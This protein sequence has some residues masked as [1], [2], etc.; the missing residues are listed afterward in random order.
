MAKLKLPDQL[1]S[2]KVLSG[3]ASRN[4]HPAFSI[5]RT[6]FDG[7]RTDAV[8]TV[9]S[10]AGD[11]YTSENIDFINEE[12]AF[13][14]SV[15]NLRGVSNYIDAVVD[16][17]PSKERVTLFLVTYD[18]PNLVEALAGKTFDDNE[19][20]DFG[21]QMS[22]LLDK[23]ERSNIFHGNIRPENIYL[24]KNGR[25]QLGGFTAF[26][27]NVEDMTYSA[28]ELSEGK[29]P[30]YTTDIY[31]LGL[32]MYEMSNGGKL[33]FEEETGNRKAATQER[34]SKAS[35][36]A[37][38]NGSEKLK[39]VV[40]IACQPDNKNRWKN[41]GN[42]KNA[43]TSIKADIPKAQER[44]V[45]APEST[46]FESNVFEENAFDEFEE[47][48]AEKD[49]AVTAAAA[50][51]GA[52]IASQTM[53]ATSESK[54]DPELEDKTGPID[55]EPEQPSY[56]EPEIDNRVF[57]D[58]QVQTKV[59]NI[60]DV[61][62]GSDKDYG[63][64]FEEEPAEKPVETID[65]TAEPVAEEFGGN[66]F[67]SQNPDGDQ[68]ET[69]KSKKGLV[70]AIIAIVVVLGALATLG[71]I[72]YQKGFFSNLFGGGSNKTQETTASQSSQN[73]TEASSVPSTTVPATTQKPTEKTTESTELYPEDITGTFYD[74]ATVVLEAQ[75]Y[76]VE[77]GSF[78]TNSD[79]DYGYVI[80]MS[81]GSD[82]P[83]KKGSTVTLTVSA[84]SGDDEDSDSNNDNEYTDDND[85]NDTENSED[86]D[87]SDSDN[88]DSGSD[89]ENSVTD[90]NVGSYKGNT[91]YLTQ[92]D[93]E[94][95]EREELNLALN[96]I[97][98]RR[99][100]IFSDESLDSYFRSQSWY[101]PKYD[102]DA[103]AKN[104]V[105]NDYEEKNIALI[106]KVQ[107]EKGYL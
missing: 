91:S 54:T 102:A 8:M 44:E 23:L 104:V 61:N 26:E 94:K 24:A 34:L 68:E 27:N 99:G 105:F 11:D 67:Y 80:S 79:Y 13:V 36:T 56:K 31:S 39:S 37:P 84:G 71:V 51:I 52:V 72:A 64:Y 7:S 95:M 49:N 45:I 86:A 63:E 97:Y 103:F 81:P 22:N 83:L 10:Y 43:L 90:T 58:Y 96:E 59:F 75:G 48:P 42:L 20:V 12:A 2:W 28:P 33:P 98:A 16:N 9:I 93:V 66:A 107:V 69:K 70:I 78:E 76:K 19:A 100:R 17:N 92:S 62:S 5:V 4:E 46:S 88:N 18:E 65:D 15:M 82:A 38:V 101:T 30:D 3:I 74:Y 53:D 41:A 85:D 40:M 50:G 57:D 55:D 87:D 106:R 1:R 73:L 14:K 29:Q 89:D 60:N 47:A 32:I 77:I 35:V 25:Y 6:E 21:I